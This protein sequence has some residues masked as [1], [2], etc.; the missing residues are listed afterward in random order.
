MAEVNSARINMAE[1]TIW[2]PLFRI[3]PAD[4]L[5]LG[6]NVKGY[7]VFTAATSLVNDA[8]ASPKRIAHF[9]S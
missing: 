9:G 2:P 6:R 3:L 8:F 4:T 5:R 1:R 7:A